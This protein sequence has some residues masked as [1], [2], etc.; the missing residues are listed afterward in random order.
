MSSLRRPPETLAGGLSGKEVSR[1]EPCSP[2][3]SQ[4]CPLAVGCSL[5]AGQPLFQEHLVG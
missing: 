3:S 5:G 4:Q 2:M 1:R